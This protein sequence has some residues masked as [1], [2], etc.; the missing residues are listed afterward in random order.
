MK[1]GII[2][3]QLVD[4]EQ[5]YTVINENEII[6]F[7]IKYKPS[8]IALGLKDTWVDFTVHKT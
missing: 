6:R 5:G 4:E 3:I 2:T 7:L 8:R 1:H